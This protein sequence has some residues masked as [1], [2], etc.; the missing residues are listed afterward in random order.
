MLDE[1][2]LDESDCRKQ[3]NSLQL[4]GYDI[5]Y[6]KQEQLRREATQLWKDAS[7]EEKAQHKGDIQHFF[8]HRGVLDRL[9]A[10]YGLAKNYYLTTSEVVERVKTGPGP[11]MLPLPDLY[12]EQA[13]LELMENLENSRHV[14]ELY[15]LR[16][17]RT[18]SER[19]SGVAN[20]EATKIKNCLRQGREL[21][22]AGKVGSLMVKPLNFFYSITAYAYAIILVNNPIRFAL[23][24]LPGSHGLDFIMDGL[25]IQFGG[26]I[27][28]GTFSE[29]VFSF[30]TLDRREAR[31]DFVQDNVA[32]LREFHQFRCTTTWGTLLSMVPE[33]RDYYRLV[34][35]RPS[36]TH[37]LEIS[38]ERS[39]RGLYRFHIGDGERQPNRADIERSFP[40]TTISEKHGQA[41]VDVPA[42]N[43]HQIRA[44]ITTD[45][46]GK[47][48]YIENPFFPITLPEACLH[49]RITSPTPVLTPRVPR[50]QAPRRKEPQ[51]VYGTTS[52][53]HSCGGLAY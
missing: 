47:S 29:M 42:S 22:L 23:E 49:F 33:L 14:Q 31:L 30:P 26:D 52:G 13:L 44:C 45:A 8:R 6:A 41:L 48:W 40:E 10:A 39:V 15:R 7:S 36:R 28:H 21:Y 1:L 5:D 9:T 4:F 17:R 11:D 20:E 16:K 3:P 35:K 12:P 25:K 51:H 43:L 53:S 32:T 37:P 34:T 2:L 24:T 38:Q 27:P 19:N 18:G 46:R 50:A